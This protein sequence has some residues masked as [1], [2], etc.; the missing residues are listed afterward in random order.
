MSGLILV[1]THTHLDLKDFRED[2]ENVLARAAESG[3]AAI[4]NSSFNI[5]SSRQSLSMAW[6]HSSLYSLIGVHPH[7]ADKVT[8]DYLADLD[9]LAMNPAVVAVGEI[10]LDYYRDLSPRDVQQKV[11]R[12]QLSMARD[13][14]LPAV[15]HD[16][17]AHGDMMDILKKD[18]VPK[19]GAVMH[20][21]SGS[22]DMAVECMK[23]GF[24]ISIAGPVTYPNA[25]R[26]KNVAAKLP[27]DRMLIE[28]DCPYL[29]PQA[30]RG[31]RNE[32]ANV[33]FVAEEIA[34][35]R[36]MPLEELAKAVSL[37]AAKIF[38]IEIPGI[39]YKK[40]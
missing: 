3:V 8:G 16:R 23:M 5:A 7:E 26:L 11:F 19:C 27:L 18:G 31:Q 12:E 36:E 32:P 15:I 13:L 35:L 40:H 37:N 28:T 25:A 24:Y 2:L 20:C 14:N 6:K 17:D 21:F 22:W 33:R 29:T 30:R 39:F 10:G 38:N 4:V 9:V 34:R 1:D